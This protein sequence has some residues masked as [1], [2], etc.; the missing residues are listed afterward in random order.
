MLDNLYTMTDSE[1]QN[2]LIVLQLDIMD[3]IIEQKVKEGKMVFCGTSTLSL[4]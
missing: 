4:N 1:F 3:R 2:M